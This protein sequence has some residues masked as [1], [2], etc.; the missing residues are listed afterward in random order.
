[1]TVNLQCITLLCIWWRALAP[2]AVD[3]GDK[4]F[5]YDKVLLELDKTIAQTKEFE[6]RQD[7]L[8]L[9]APYKYSTMSREELI[10]LLARTVPKPGNE[11]F[12]ADVGDL[13]YAMDEMEESPEQVN[14]EK[15]QAKKIES[16]YQAR[17]ALMTNQD[18]T[19]WLETIQFTEREYEFYS[20]TQQKQMKEAT[21]RHAEHALA[22]YNKS[23]S[24]PWL[25]AAVVTNGLRGDKNV[26][27]LKAA[28]Q[29][30]PSSIA[31]NTI[32]FYLIDRLISK[33]QFA[34]AQS[35][36]KAQVSKTNLTATN[37]N[38]F[39][40]QMLAVASN[41]SDYLRFAR[42]RPADICTY[43]SYIPSDWANIE[44]SNKPAST[45]LT[46]DEEVAINLNR[47]LPLTRLVNMA[48]T[49]SDPV[50]RGRLA[51]S[52]WLK[53]HLL[54]EKN[55]AHKLTTIFA[56]SYPPLKKTNHSGRSEHRG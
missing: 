31:F 55:Q 53:A 13:T 29:L 42:M 49:E 38:L 20:V 24:L 36:L 8:D 41:T 11:R 32:D 6:M 51:R 25:V 35:R 56:A 28:K 10:D 1:M 16:R 52:A 19:D 54:G 40:A 17:E 22:M 9:R 43:Y 15:E 48:L 5:D 47:Y 12:G 34:E 7:L 14:D 3:A 18:L 37:Q 26:E 23:H 4:N 2:K 44:R 46:F 30:P 27:L 45:P 21:R 33:G 50:L 39:K